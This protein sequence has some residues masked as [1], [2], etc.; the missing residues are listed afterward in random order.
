MAHTSWLK[1]HEGKLAQSGIRAGLKQIMKQAT[2]KLGPS[3]ASFPLHPAFCRTMKI[4]A[5]IR[6]KPEA[7][8]PGHMEV[9][10]LLSFD[11]TRLGP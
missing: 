5:P 11:G 1:Y 3:P 9:R 7:H 6:A 10:L 8:T 4:L 2:E